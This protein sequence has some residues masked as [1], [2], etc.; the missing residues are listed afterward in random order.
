MTLRSL[1]PALCAL[2][3]LVLCLPGTSHAAIPEGAEYSEAYF[4]SGDGTVLH[5]DVLRPK[6]LPKDTRTPVILTVT[7]Y[8]NHLGQNQPDPAEFDGEG[9]NARFDDFINGAKVLERG[10]TYV[11]VDLRGFGGS[12]GC[13]DWGGPGEQM[14]VKAAVEWAAS[15]QWSTGRVALYGKSYDGWTGLMGLAQQ[16]QGLAAV[17]SMEPVYDGYR[18]LYMHGVRFLTSVSTNVLFSAIDAMPGRPTDATQYHLNGTALNGGCYALNIGQQQQDDPAVDFWKARNLLGKVAGVTTPLFLMQGFL[19]DNTKP[20]GAFAFWNSLGGTQNR[21]WFGPWDHVRGNDRQGGASD[22]ALLAGRA[23][24]FDEVMRFL[25][26]HVKGVP[27][28]DAPVDKDPKIAVQ[29]SDGA[30]RSETQWPPADAQTSV[31]NLKAGTYSDDGDNNGTGS[32]AGQGIWTFSPPLPHAAQLAGT[33]RLIAEVAAGVPRANLVADVYDVAADGQAT[34]VSRGAMLIR[35]SGRVELELY[36]QDWTF[37]PGHR[38]GVLLTESNAEW[39]THLPTNTTVMVSSAR[40]TLPFLRFARPSDLAGTKAAKLESH[41]R[42]APF[43]VSAETITAGTDAAFPIP[44][45]Q[46]PRP[47]AGAAGPGPA[48]PAR[49]RLVVQVGRRGRSVVVSGTAPPR[50]RVTVRLQRVTRRAGRTVHRTVATRRTF[51]QLGSFR[52]SAPLAR[53]NG[54][55]FR[56]LVTAAQ[57]TAKLS[58]RTRTLT[59]RGLRATPRR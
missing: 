54:L 7:P 35:Q 24:W 19:E 57:G 5:A 36:G 10:Y 33:P 26:H 11:Y 48:K 21:A 52:V 34:L 37:A 55:R 53:R 59:V 4:P 44:A 46:V 14:D 28:V 49:P 42:S 8:G 31:A 16:P 12:A 51:A 29:G 25:D 38:V 39:W 23:G 15:Q 32:G 41:L 50:A 9:P 3:A 18:Y 43:A 56:A 47:V 20:D 1:P 27:L 6:G 22:G 45:A 30:W 40:M 13:N 58:A 17:V 2:V